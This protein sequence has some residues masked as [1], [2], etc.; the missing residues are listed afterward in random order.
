MSDI[1]E[2]MMKLNSNNEKNVRSLVRENFKPI[3]DKRVL[4]NWLGWRC[5][6]F[7]FIMIIIIFIFGLIVLILFG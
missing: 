5:T 4:E 2:N 1:E 3:I 6:S 7:I